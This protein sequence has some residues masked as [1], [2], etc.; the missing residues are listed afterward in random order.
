M[1]MK[2][3]QS[4]YNFIYD[5]L[6]KDQIVMYNSFTGAL[7]VVKEEQYRQFTAYLESGKEIEDKTFLDN[8]LKCGYL[9]PAEVDERFLIKTKMLSGRFN[10][11]VLS[12]TIAPTMACNFRC[13]YC[14]EQGHYGNRLMDEK[15]QESIIQFVKKYLP[16]IEHLNIVWFGGEPLLGMSVVKNLSKELIK[17]CE[18]KEVKYT[19]IMVTNGYLLTKE[20]AEKLKEWRLSSLQVTVDGPKEI[21]DSRKPL[22]NGGGTYDVIMENLKQV[23]GI[24]PISLRINVDL[25]NISAAD[26]VMKSLKESDILDGVSPYLGLVIPYNDNYQEEKCFSDEMYS[27]YNLQFLLKND[28]P[29]MKTYPRPRGNYCVAD[30]CNGWVIDEVGNMYK[31]WNDIG[32]PEKSVGNIN[33][34]DNYLQRTDLLQE[35]SSFDPMTYEECKDCKMLPTCLGGCPHNRAEGRRVCEQRRFYMQ[36]YLLECTKSLLAKKVNADNQKK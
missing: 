7:A 23:K 2:L 11:R 21:H 16:K 13:V 10:S 36:E 18:E 32:I 25:D 24:L 27:K 34:G 29:L 22:L 9:L 6:G 26:E 8:L 31:C 15:T 17:L 5:D 14:F 1:E 12:L 19:A 28:I 3:K 33:L 4:E 30:F 20:V 35:Y